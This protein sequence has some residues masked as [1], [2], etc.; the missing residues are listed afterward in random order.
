M[1]LGIEILDLGLRFGIEIGNQD[2]GLRIG[3]WQLGFGIRLG[4]GN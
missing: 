2:W 3:K 4:I 1:G